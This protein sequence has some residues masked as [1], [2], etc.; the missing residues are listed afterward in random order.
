MVSIE[1]PGVHRTNSMTSELR[2]SASLQIE[3]LKTASGTEQA[4]SW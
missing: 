3:W 1:T 4:E 2:G